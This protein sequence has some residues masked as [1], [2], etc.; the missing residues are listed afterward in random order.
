MPEPA[1]VATRALSGA[2][3]ALARDAQRL[4]DL[5]LLQAALSEYRDRFDEYPDTGGSVQT[6]CAYSELDKGCDL[7][8]VLDDEEEGILED[9]LG[10]P[11]VNG[12]W[13]ASDGQTYSIWMLRE[14]PGNAGDPVCPEVIPHLEKV[15]PL[16]CVTGV[17]ASS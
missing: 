17:A 12:Y 6:I 14:G 1:A 9:P 16:F 2:S 10:E 5:A 4:E 11:L 7:K 15:G 3:D 13:Y 8:K